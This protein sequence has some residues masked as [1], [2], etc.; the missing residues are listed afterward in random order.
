M[1]L[2][3]LEEAQGKAA[4]RGIFSILRSVQLGVDGLAVNRE[5][6]ALDSAACHFFVLPKSPKTTTFL[7]CWLVSS[8]RK[9]RRGIL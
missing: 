8:E 1:A 7:L 6:A 9:A 5:R 2:P 3:G 4:N